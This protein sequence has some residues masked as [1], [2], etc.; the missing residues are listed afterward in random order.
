MDVSELIHQLPVLQP[1]REAE[2]AQRMDSNGQ[3]YL[4]NYRFHVH[5]GDLRIN[6]DLHNSGCCLLVTGHLIV[7]GVYSDDSRGGILLVGGSLWASHVVSWSA[8]CVAGHAWIDGLMLHEYNDWSFECGGIVCARAFYN[9]DKSCSFDT[10]R[11]IAEGFELDHGGAQWGPDPLRMLGLKDLDFDEVRERVRAAHAEGRSP[12]G[13]SEP[14]PDEAGPRLLMHPEAPADVLLQALAL[15]TSPQ[16]GAGR[17]S[18]ALARLSGP[19]GTLGADPARDA[20]ELALMVAARRRL[21]E[22]VEAPLLS[23]PAACVRQA[24]AAAPWLSEAGVRRLGDDPVAA[25]RAALA[26]RRPLASALQA[27]LAHDPSTVVR[28]ALVRAHGVAEAVW[29]PALA[30]DTAAAVRQAVARVRKLAPDLTQRLL[31]DEDFGVRRTLLSCQP[32]DEAQWRPL[33][34][35]PD[36]RM[37]AFLAEAAVEGSPPF[38]RAMPAREEALMRLLLDPAPEVRKPAAIGWLDPDFY[39]R[40]AEAFATD[41]LASVRWAWALHSRR[42]DLLASLADDPS[43]RVRDQVA[44][45]PNTPAAALTGMA[46]RYVAMDQGGTFSAKH[47]DLFCLSRNPRLPAEAIEVLANDALAG[48]SEAHPNT[49]FLRL[50]EIVRTRLLRGDRAFRRLCELLDEWT[51]EPPPQ[52]IDRLMRELLAA[53]SEQLQCALLPSRYYPSDLLDAYLVRYLRRRRKSGCYEMRDLAANPNL[54]PSSLRKIGASLLQA[55]DHELMS[56]LCLNPAAPP[57]VLAALALGM[58]DEGSRRE[59]RIAAWQWHGLRAQDLPALAQGALEGVD[60]RVMDEAALDVPED[61]EI[62]VLLREGQSLLKDAPGEALERFEEA[63]ELLDEMPGEAFRRLR[64]RLRIMHGCQ[65][66]VCHEEHGEDLDQDHKDELREKGLALARSL[67]AEIPAH[68]IQRGSRHGRLEAE[69]IRHAQQFLALDAFQREA[70]PARLR[71][72]VARLDEALGYP[73]DRAKPGLRRKD[74]RLLKAKLRVKLGEGSEVDPRLVDEALRSDVFDS[75]FGPLAEPVLRRFTAESPDDLDRWTALAFFER[76][77]AHYAAAIEIWTRILDRLADEEA[78]PD[79]WRYSQE[80]LLYFRAQDRRRMGEPQGAIED[81]GAALEI[82]GEWTA[83]WI[84]RGWLHCDAGRWEAAAADFQ[85]ALDLDPDE[86]EA[87]QGLGHALSWLDR[88]DEALPHLQAQADRD[89]SAESL[90]GLAWALLQLK[91]TA[92]ALSTVEAA[93]AM[94]EAHA[95]A[96][97]TKAAVLLARGRPEEALPWAARAAA[98]AP[99]RADLLDCHGECLHARGRAQ[100]AQALLARCRALE[101]D[102]DWLDYT[103]RPGYGK[104]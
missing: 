63:L 49:G 5:E 52:V 91:R 43:E 76:D 32:L 8:L 57:E 103:Q 72:A 17:L 94:D 54:R 53:P 89:P 80:E 60:P 95:D 62:E 22:G 28:E 92:E 64:C 67:L 23:H 46:K 12:F 9:R 25:V 66:L 101:P 34:D 87:E 3:Y 56:G 70:E 41:S 15:G 1:E 20:E 26:A 37:R 74:L 13:R 35:S 27:A 10:S 61:D 65:L 77:R 81:L 68:A 78:D 71:E 48:R 21:P 96:L 104:T 85:A 75:D 31:A 44:A 16:A 55:H 98:L 93:L 50:L 19:L 6:G 36:A 4:E 90:N 97:S 69:V 51:E 14:L 2:I 88:Y 47:F 100:D 29:L 30:A 24:A 33:M 59:A 42:G 39:D 84:E 82:D 40:H 83:P 58:A 73:L 79:D 45:N 18:A 102:R 11:A 86:A 99:D 7:D 38:T